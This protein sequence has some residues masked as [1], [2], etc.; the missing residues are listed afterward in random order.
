LAY[1]SVSANALAVS[2]LKSKGWPP[3]G[4]T[5]KSQAPHKKTA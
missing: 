1:G 3:K 2:L 5:R 4:A